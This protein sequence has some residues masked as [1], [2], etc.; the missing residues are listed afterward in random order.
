MFE[1]P[2]QNHS[3]KTAISA[4]TSILSS[5]ETIQCKQAR[6]CPVTQQDRERIAMDM[7]DGV[8]QSL[9]ALAIQIELLSHLD[10][11]HPDELR[12]LAKGINQVIED[13]RHY[14][15]DSLNSY[16]QQMSLRQAIGSILKELHPPLDIVLDINIPEKMPSF[17]PIVFENICL[18]IKEAVS[19]VLRHAHAQTIQ[20]TA[21][22][23]D[24][25][26]RFLIV[27]DGQ[28]F[29]TEAISQR[30]G[31][32]L[33]NLQRR[34]EFNGGKAEIKSLL[35]FGTIVMLEIPF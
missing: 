5:E 8:I 13:I 10:N 29:S 26:Y 1:R 7:H 33:S 28:G 19:N 16:P 12:P 6:N 11:I 15:R 27:D 24:K 30:E 25:F 9:F 14:I 22:P 34:A 23:I 4:F 31:M 3:P 17:S 20:I 21:Y 18:I 35:G 32:G 2:Y